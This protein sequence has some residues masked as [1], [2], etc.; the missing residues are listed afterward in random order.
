VWRPTNVDRPTG[1]FVGLIIVSLVLITVDLR[2][3]GA[4]IGGTMREGVQTV[5]T[6]IQRVVS[7]GTRPVAEFFEDLSDIFSLRSDNRRLR[8]SANWKP[9]SVSSHR[10]N[11]IRLWPRSSP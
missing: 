9:Y 8:A 1:V 4:G 7:A 10:R 2:A 3:S 6:P 11:S 5:F